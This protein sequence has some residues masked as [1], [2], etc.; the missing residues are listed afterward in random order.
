PLRGGEGQVHARFPGRGRRAPVREGD[1]DRFRAMMAL[2][3]NPDLLVQHGVE[4]HGIPS[5]VREIPPSVPQRHDERGGDRGEGERNRAGVALR[6][7]LNPRPAGRGLRMKRSRAVLVVFVIIA[8]A[9]A[10]VGLAVRLPSANPTG[11]APGPSLVSYNQ[12]IASKYHP[13]LSSM[14]M[15]AVNRGLGQLPRTG[16]VNRPAP[17]PDLASIPVNGFRFVN[18]AS[19]MPQTETSVDVDPANIN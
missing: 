17:T 18:D 7:A 6:A 3:S 8:L 19:Y 15:A 5:A 4:R 11:N 14:G 13:P 9:A 2:R 1:R 10:T 16:S 12:G